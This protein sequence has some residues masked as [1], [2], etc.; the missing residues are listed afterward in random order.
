MPKI[1]IVDDSAFARRSIRHALESSGHEI[2]EA[3]SGLRALEMVQQVAPDIITIDLLM[4]DMPGGELLQHLRSLV[5]DSRFVIITA[6]IQDA[7]RE[8]LMAAGADAFI[9]KPTDP[10]IVIEEISGLLSRS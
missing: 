10:K 6:D 9:N 4:P 2:F 5:P 3:E 7:T 1:L 8:Q